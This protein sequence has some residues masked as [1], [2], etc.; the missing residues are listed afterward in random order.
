M[1]GRVS[2]CRDGGRKTDLEKPELRSKA[3]PSADFAATGKRSFSSLPEPSGGFRGKASVK[4]TRVTLRLTGQQKATLKSLNSPKMAENRRER[5][6]GAQSSTAA[7]EKRQKDE[8]RKITQRK[9][10][11]ICL[12]AC[13]A[14]KAGHAQDRPFAVVQDASDGQA[15]LELSKSKRRIGPSPKSYLYGPR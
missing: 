4:R 11:R 1:S 5:T 10:S 15:M 7:T 6:Q 8:G 3:P 9:Q 2:E 14:T 13:P 12:P